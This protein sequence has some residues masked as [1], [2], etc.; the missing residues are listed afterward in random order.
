MITQQV[1][2]QKLHTQPFASC[3]I[4]PQSTMTLLSARMP[5]FAI[6]RTR[7]VR[8]CMREKRAPPPAREHSSNQVH[9]GNEWL[10]A[11]SSHGAVRLLASCI[12]VVDPLVGAALTYSSKCI[13]PL[14]W[15]TISSMLDMA[16]GRPAVGPVGAGC[17]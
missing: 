4:F 14:N 6:C 15:H 3:R 9:L 2:T 16:C 5:A 17:F 12:S 8:H 11:A 7:A 1:Q 10:H 13:P